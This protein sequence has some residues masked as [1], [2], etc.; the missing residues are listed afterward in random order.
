MSNQSKSVQPIETLLLSSQKARMNQYDMMYPTINRWLKQS[1]VVDSDLLQE[2]HECSKHH[3]R[4][5]R[6]SKEP[7]RVL[8]SLINPKSQFPTM[9]TWSLSSSDSF[10]PTIE[11]SSD[12]ISEYIIQQS[13]SF[14]S[15]AEVHS[16]ISST[17]QLKRSRKPRKSVTPEIVRSIVLQYNRD[18]KPSI[19]VIAE[20]VGIS[21]TT[22]KKVVKQIREGMFDSDGVV[23][24]TN[25]KS[26][27]KPKVT[28]ETASRVKEVLTATTRTTLATAKQILETENILLSKSTIHRIAQRER[29]SHQKISLRPEI[30]FS[31]R[32][33]Q[34]RSDYAEEVNGL[35]DEELWFLDETGFNLHVS[36]IR[37]WSEVGQTPVQPV[38]PSKGKNM[39]VLMCIASEGIQ[40]FEMKEGAY[41]A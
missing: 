41:R 2:E 20:N 5:I 39:S 34:L 23:H 13:E 8:Y 24:Y 31:E 27:R 28:S 37:C 22:A 38:Q 18:Q 15:L 16:H 6:S 21:Y 25:K 36:P 33:L 9:D 19:K 30:V 26:G 14:E 10:E 7:L 11:S 1:I 12:E 32:V 17:R 3:V 35:D 40:H 29:L 4:F